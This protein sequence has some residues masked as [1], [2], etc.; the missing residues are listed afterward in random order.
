MI[1]ESV[2]QGPLIWPTIEENGMTRPKKY[3]ELTPYEAIQADC[4]VK[5]TNIILQGTSLTKQE[6]ECKLY[7]EFDKFAYKKG[8][9]LCDFYLRFYLLLNDMTINNVK[10][11]QFQV[12]T[13]FLNTLLAEWSKFVMDV[14][15]VQ[16]L[17]TT[18]IDQLHSYLGQH[19]FHANEIA[20]MANLSYFGSDAL[21]EVNNSN[22]D[23][24]MLH[25]GV[26]YHKQSSVVNHIETETASDSNIITYSQYLHETQQEAVHNSS[27]STQQDALILSVI[28]QLRTQVLNCTKINLE[29]KSVNDTSTT[30]L[31]RYKGQ[32]MFLKEGKNVDFMHRVTVSDACKQ[33]VEIDRLKQILS[34][35][36]KEKESLIQTV[37]LLKN[38]FKKEESK[39]IDKEFFLEK[40]IKLL[41]NIVVKRDQL[42]Q[43]KA[44]QL[45]PKL[46]DGN[47]IEKTNA[48]VIYDIKET[49][50]LTEESHS[51][52]LS[53][54]KDPMV[55]EE[56]VNTKPIYYAA[57]NL[58][59]KDFATQCVPQ[60]ELST[61]Q[62]SCPSLDPIPFNRPTIVEV[63]S[64]LSKV[65]MGSWGFEHIKAC[66]KDEIIPFVKA[67]KD[68]F[69]T[70]DQY[71]IDELTEVQNVFH[72]MEQ[73]VD[74]HLNA[75]V[76]NASVSMSECIKCL[77][78][79]NELLNKQ[80]FIEKEKYDKL[81]SSYATL[82]K[83][84]AYL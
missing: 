24:N 16:D 60:S 7:D 18:N 45:E 28:E 20:L 17:H 58:L 11:E 5:A 41:D 50:M 44:Q 2:E 14:K 59:S 22:L 43:T 52:M 37:T 54:Q 77:E 13:K 34:E 12:N 42:A 69:N 3:S 81:L 23:N 72:Q 47:V 79:K 19:E 21:A 33:Y 61:K 63:P 32:F 31:D 80:D 51:K 75:A 39:N 30:E 4:D 64:K 9:T 67:L 83:N 73:A 65:I 66:F 40:N 53:K 68:L 70:F 10:L 25:Q 1:L 74:Q 55:S 78:L 6:R 57:L 26:T 62:V 15:L 76:N 48:I 29:N 8:E 49:L 56:K 84:I 71:L 27:P 35:Q 82:L 46:Y 36:V 38:D